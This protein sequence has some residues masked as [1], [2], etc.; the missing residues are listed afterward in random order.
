MKKL[1]F[2]ILCL[3]FVF[4]NPAQAKK[5][6]QDM[7]LTGVVQD[8]RAATLEDGNEE[9]HKPKKHKAAKHKKSHKAKKQ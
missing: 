5:K 7:P 1:F 9:T 3:S 2:A 6:A 8:V 4:T